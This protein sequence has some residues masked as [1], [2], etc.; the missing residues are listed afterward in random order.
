MSS[1][2]E[3]IQSR[4]DKFRWRQPGQ[5]SA[6]CPAHDDKGPSLSVR[7]TPD[8]AILLHCFAGC[9][10]AEI[11]GAMG[12]ELHDLFPPRQRPGKAPRKI[13]RVLTPSQ[14]LELVENECNLI[15]IAGGILAEGRPLSA[16]DRQ[17]VMQAAGRVLAIAREARNA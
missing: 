13:A 2:I 9:T 6:C 10:V 4:V 3:L 15:A 8:G 1:P 16:S 7:E 14:A 17:R 11:V 12:L 5:A